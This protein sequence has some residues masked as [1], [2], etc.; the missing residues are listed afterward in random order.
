[1]QKELDLDTG[2]LYAKLRQ[3]GA[4][5]GWSATGTL[6]DKANHC[7]ALIGKSDSGMCLKGKIEA[8]KRDLALEGNFAD[9]LHAA[10]TRLEI[11][12]DAGKCMHLTADECLAAAKGS[13]TGSVVSSKS[14]QVHAFDLCMCPMI[15]VPGSFGVRKFVTDM[16]WRHFTTQSCCLQF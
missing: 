12:V 6:Q 8:L 15:L 16:A 2:P 1:M 3:A 13:G 11:P 10:C 7:L 4:L 5:L 14:E 9:V